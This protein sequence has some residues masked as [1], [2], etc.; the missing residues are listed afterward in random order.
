M[1]RFQISVYNRGMHIRITSINDRS[2]LTN[3]CTPLTKYESRYVRG[4]G[5]QRVKKETYATFHPRTNTYGLHRSYLDDL[6]IHLRRMNVGDSEI[7]TVIEPQYRPAKVELKLSAVLKL[8]DKQVPIVDF[9]CKGHSLSILPVQTGVG[10]TV[11]SLTSIARLGVRGVLSMTS[12]DVATWISEIKWIYDGEYTDIVRLVRGSADLKRLIKDGK[13]DS[14]SHPIIIITLGTMRNYLT[15]F[16]RAGRSSYGCRPLDFYRVIK[17]GIRVVDEA[18]ENL[19][20]QFRHDIETHCASVL[21][22]SAT[23]D[24]HDRMT[25]ELYD[26]IYPPISR[27]L[28][29][30]WNRYIRVYALSYRAADPSEIK[31][32]NGMGQ[33]NHGVYEDYIMRD[34]GRAKSYYG[35]ISYIVNK[36]WFT[37]R[38]DGD[39]CVIFLASVK[40]CQQ[41]R[42][43]LQVKYPTITTI[44]YTGETEESELYVHDLVITTPGSAGT[45]KDIKGLTVGIAM[46]AVNSKQRNIQMMGRLR[47]LADGRYV[48]Y[49]YAFCSNIDA[50]VRYHKTKI[51][52]F[53]SKAHSHTTMQTTFIV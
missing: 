36:S 24:S 25:N 45:G 4:R 21:Y 3:F 28:G 41:L 5:V 37:E 6:L 11:C 43:F 47:E 31:C 53:R 48:N 7:E 26:R 50:H 22:L 19:H 49:Y 1:Y 32:T 34:S 51:D 29:L 52:T 30:E 17:V 39:K 2:I 40:M 33:Y 46:V 27:Y 20:M 18:H 9:V 38:K 44:A 23:I 14:I 35:M 15:E 8:K 16:E 13:D 10:K 42:E 12:R